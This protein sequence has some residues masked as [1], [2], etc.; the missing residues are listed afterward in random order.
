MRT[1]KS[2]HFDMTSIIGIETGRL[3]CTRKVDK[4]TPIYYGRYVPIHSEHTW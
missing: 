1:K 2:H 4:T 3:G